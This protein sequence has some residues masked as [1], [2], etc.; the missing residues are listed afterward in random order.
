MKTSAI[1]LLHFDPP[2]SAPI[3]TTGRVKLAGHYLGS[4]SKPVEVRLAEH[5]AGKGSPLVRAAIAS[6]C[7]V[8]LA[9]S[10]PGGRTEEKAAKRAHHHSRLCPIC[11][12]R[13]EPVT[14]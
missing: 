10:W 4:T 8:R 13:P 9:A 7:A 3:G 11:N 12:P 14:A 1:Y 2:Y 6:G 5:V